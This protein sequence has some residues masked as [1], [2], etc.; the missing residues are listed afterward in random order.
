MLRN[1]SGEVLTIVVAQLF[2]CEASSNVIMMIS[3]FT[4][5]SKLACKHCP[6]VSSVA[7]PGNIFAF[8]AQLFNLIQWSHAT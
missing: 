6:V 3:T 7:G 4:L 8:N 5:G 1:N 2:Q